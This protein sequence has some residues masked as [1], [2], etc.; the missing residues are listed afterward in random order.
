MDM[1]G[2]I[3]RLYKRQVLGMQA[4][5]NLSRTIVNL[6]QKPDISCPYLGK[7]TEMKSGTLKLVN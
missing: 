6:H 7:T 2:Q 1:H 3:V 4:H 5:S